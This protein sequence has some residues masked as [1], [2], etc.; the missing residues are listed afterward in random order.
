MSPSCNK[1]MF[2]FSSATLLKL[3]SFIYYLQN[4]S[5]KENLLGLNDVQ[6]RTRASLTFAPVAGYGH[7]K[8]IGC[9]E[10]IHQRVVFCQSCTFKIKIWQLTWIKRL[11]SFKLGGGGEIVLLRKVEKLCQFY[12]LSTKYISKECN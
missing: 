12:N 11:L 10:V 8:Q 4:L 9:S 5:A 3:E 2:C 1:L 6:T 7:W